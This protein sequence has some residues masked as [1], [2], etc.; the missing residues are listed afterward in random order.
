ML[1]CSSWMYAY[2]MYTTP[3]AM[4]PANNL[5]FMLFIISFY[6][7]NFI[8]FIYFIYFLISFLCLS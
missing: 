7:F 1:I 6:L 3:F 2:W 5:L 8:Y 4:Q